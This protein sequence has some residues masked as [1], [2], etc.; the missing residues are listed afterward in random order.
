MADSSKTEQAT[1]RQRLKARERGQVTRSR[2]LTGALSMFAVAGVVTLMARQGAGQWTDYFRNTLA[3]AQTESIETNGPLLFWTTVEGLRWVVPIQL[4]ALA[5]ALGVGFAQGGFV[6]APEALSLKFERLSPVN[7]LQQLFSPTGLSTILKSLLPFAAIIWVG[8]AC[9]SGHWG[10]ILASSYAEP[11]QFVVLVGGMLVEVLWKSGL[12]LLVWAGADYLLLWLKSEGD[13]KMSRQ[14]I[15]DELKST[16][17]NPASKARIRRLQRQARRK[18]M[19]KAT[20]S[21]TVVVTNPTHYAVALKF[22]ISMPAPIVVAKGLDLLAAKIKEIARER[23]IPIMENR[24]LA[25]ALYK[26]VDVGDEIPGA[27]YHAVAEIL[28]LVF[29]AQEEVKRREAQRRAASNPFGGVR[30]Q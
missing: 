9:L 17:G 16:E 20:Q 11:R 24:A 21:A 7:R 8:Y 30:T 29:R 26:A 18:L 14:D 5:V 2:E 4:A 10:Q 6:F 23:D 25:Q 19:I 27:L 28:V 3:S 12:I 22:E 15:R 1:P 13:L